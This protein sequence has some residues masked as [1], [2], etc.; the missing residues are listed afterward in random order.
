VT[1]VLTDRGRAA[2]LI[3]GAAVRS[4]NAYLARKIGPREVAALRTGLVA[5]A[6]LE[7][8]DESAS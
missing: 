6:Q 3:V 1:L 2:A 8:G 5:L 4:V 7:H